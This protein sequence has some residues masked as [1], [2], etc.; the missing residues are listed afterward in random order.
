MEFF[1]VQIN[2]RTSWFF[3][4]SIGKVVRAN[5]RYPRGTM[6]LQKDLD[7]IHIAKPGMLLDVIHTVEHH[8]ESFGQIFLEETTNDID[9]VIRE[10]RTRTKFGIDDLMIDLLLISILEMSHEERQSIG[11][12][13]YPERWV[14]SVHLEYQHTQ[15]PVVDWKIELAAIGQRTTGWSTYLP[16][17]NHGQEWFPGPETRVSRREYRLFR[18]QSFWRNLKEKEERQFRSL[19]PNGLLPKSHILM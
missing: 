5:V 16:C 7:P 3:I 12:R 9:Q 17:C 13:P 14:A 19:R 4:F 15:G 18:D 11:R 8:A 1:L 6:L 10:R 2:R